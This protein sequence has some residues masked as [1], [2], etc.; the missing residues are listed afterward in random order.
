MSLIFRLITMVAIIFSSAAIAME[1]PVYDFALQPYNQDVHKWFPSDSG[2]YSK[3]LVSKSYQKQQLKEFYR[4]YYAS[5]SQGYSP[6]SRSM[7]TSILPEVKQAQLQ[8]LQQFDNQDKPLNLRHYAENFKEH[9][10]HWLQ[11]LRHNMRINQLNNTEFSAE[12]RSIALRDTYARA[13]PD[14]APDFY[15]LSLPGQGFP[16]DNLQESAVWAGTPLYVIQV[17]NDKAWSLVL[18]PDGYYA[19]VNSNDIAGV[20]GDFIGKWQKAAKTKL[21]AVIQTAA[22]VTD[23]ARNF[24]FCAYI[25]AVFPLKEQG[26]TYTSIMIPVR[27]NDNQAKITEGRMPSKAVATM[28]LAATPKN[29]T[30]I[31]HQLQNRPYGWGGVYF[32]NDCSQEMKSIFTP[33]GI[34]LPRNSEQ[35]SQLHSTVDLSAK[36]TEERLNYLKTHGHP[37]MTVIYVGGHV[38]LYVGNRKP[39]GEQ[40]TEA[41]TYQNVW[42]LSPVNKDKRYIIGQSVFFP[43][44][45][46][47]PEN[48]DVHSQAGKT[49]FKLIY[50]DRLT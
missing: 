26:D 38:M 2:E 21:M 27:G 31:I 11:N 34:W 1:V 30:K 16:F 45:K 12:N 7:V 32:Y 50:L 5:D 29:M 17:S 42:G 39:P 23:R 41:L 37:L 10:A 49:F 13:L 8:L 46:Y 18:T 20:S 40:Q 9:D 4:H 36:N 28:P 19:W 14:A 3:P 6:W 43:L 22:P 44:L 35:Q 25:G 47:Y 48:P 15:H 33:L 24:K